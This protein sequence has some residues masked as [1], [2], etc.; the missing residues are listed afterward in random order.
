M[1]LRN[2]DSNWN[3]FCNERVIAETSNVRKQTKMDV[4]PDTTGCDPPKKEA[5]SDRV[6]KNHDDNTP[7][8]GSEARLRRQ[9]LTIEEA[10]DGGVAGPLTAGGGVVKFAALFVLGFGHWRAV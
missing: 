7:V 10:L 9:N 8:T 2:T 6:V 3:T 5:A 1:I 4:D